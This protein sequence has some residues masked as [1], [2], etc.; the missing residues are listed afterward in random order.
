M[1]NGNNK[2][3]KAYVRYDGTGRVVPSSL[4]LARFKP[5]VGNYQE[6]DAY[7]CCNVAPLPSNCIEFVVDTTDGTSF[8]LSFTTSVPINFT[9]E[10]GDGTTYPEVGGGG[11]YEESHTYPETGQQYTARIC[12]DSPE[13]VT[14]LE[15][16][17]ND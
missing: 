1:A 3:L 2:R 12:F 14:Q 4:I 11:F 10:W 6:I 8:T 13:S 7:E 9:I 17:G 16:Y 15:F 5:A